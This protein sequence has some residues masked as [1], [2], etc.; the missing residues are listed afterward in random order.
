MR[1]R[2]TREADPAR[3]FVFRDEARVDPERGEGLAGEEEDHVITSHTCT[4]SFMPLQIFQN[5]VQ[6]TKP[7]VSAGLS[8]ILQIHLGIPPEQLDDVRVGLPAAVSSVKR[9]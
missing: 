1:I 7:I 2:R 8:K 4:G 3:G 9:T 6:T 5:L